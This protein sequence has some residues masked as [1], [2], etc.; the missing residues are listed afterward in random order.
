MSLALAGRLV[1]RFG[2]IVLV[3]SRPVHHGRHDCAVRRRVTAQLVGDQTELPGLFIDTPH[4]AR[5]KRPL[6]LGIQS[7][8]ERILPQGD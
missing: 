6:S 7:F 2:S 4:R 5:W 3:L 1:R 8:V